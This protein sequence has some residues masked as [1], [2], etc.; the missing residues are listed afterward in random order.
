[1]LVTDLLP[2][3]LTAFIVAI[4]LVMVFDK[5]KANND[6]RRVLPLFLVRFFGLFWAIAALFYCSRSE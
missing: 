6:Q 1:M 2:I 4:I 5:S 3:C